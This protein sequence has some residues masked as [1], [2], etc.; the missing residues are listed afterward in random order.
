MNWLEKIKNFKYIFKSLEDLE[1]VHEELKILSNK[2]LEKREELVEISG[3]TT[4]SEEERK[5]IK[6]KTDECVEELGKLYKRYDEIYPCMNY[7]VHKRVTKIGLD[8]MKEDF[9]YDRIISLNELTKVVSDLG[10][11]HKTFPDDQAEAIYFEA[12][13]DFPDNLL[14]VIAIEGIW[15]KIQSYPFN[16]NITDEEQKLRFL[17]DSNNYNCQTRYFKTHIDRNGR[18][19]IERQDFIESYKN[20]EDLA[21]KLSFAVRTAYDF[22]KER[23]EFFKEVLEIN[24]KHDPE[25]S[26]K[27]LAN[28]KD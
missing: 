25:R 22:F 3:T 20:T 11:R 27:L 6:D 2:I 13:E 26:N 23:K 7:L 15:L 12:D 18:V 10:V 21:N 1:S 9:C 24:Q 8:F 19:S 4:D 16:C 14:V 28:H 5:I 17:N